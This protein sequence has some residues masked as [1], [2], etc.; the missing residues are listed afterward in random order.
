MREICSSND[1]FG[2]AVAIK[3]IY[4]NILQGGLKN[5][6]CIFVL[7]TRCIDCTFILEHHKNGIYFE[8]KIF[9]DLQKI[10]HRYIW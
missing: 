3:K 8:N 10:N 5:P 6:L 1:G 7:R 9:Y 2:I 4:S